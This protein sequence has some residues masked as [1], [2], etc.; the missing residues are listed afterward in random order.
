MRGLAY[1]AVV[2]GSVVAASAGAQT[3]ASQPAAAAPTRSIET[4]V[5]AP[6]T[7]SPSQSQS[8]SSAAVLADAAF[9]PRAPASPRSDPVTRLLDREAYEPGQGLVRWNSGEV[10]VAN[11]DTG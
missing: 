7:A 6:V 8:K 3:L 10:S 11:R 4:F 9:A 5:S 2:M 1:L